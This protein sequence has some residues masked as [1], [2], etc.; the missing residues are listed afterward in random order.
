MK[1]AEQEP[2]Q[3]I[4]AL[5]LKFLGSSMGRHLGLYGFGQVT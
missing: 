2:V 5:A 4:K 3:G 1:S